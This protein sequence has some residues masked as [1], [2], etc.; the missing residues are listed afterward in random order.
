MK[1]EK[2]Q[3][4]TSTAKRVQQYIKDHPYIKHCLKN[5][6]LNYSA[7]S[8]KISKELNITNKTSIEA[9][10]VAA[11]RYEHSLSK[12]IDNDKNIK[13][14]LAHSE[15]QIKNKIVVYILRKPIDI[16]LMGQFRKKIEQDTGTIYVI[17]GVK[18]YTL[19][20]QEMYSELVKQT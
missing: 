5:G 1:K 13:N 2:N 7:L 8:R 9:I 19:I 14:I 6:L 3:K 20:T 11:R 16:K 18:N 15:Y 10:L 4:G 12:E 17:E